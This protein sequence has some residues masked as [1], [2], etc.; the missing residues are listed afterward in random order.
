MRAKI[1]ID[2]GIVNMLHDDGLTLRE[3][4]EQIGV[5]YGT[6]ARRYPAHKDD[7]RSF[8][9]DKA[10]ALRKAG[11]SDAKIADELC[12]EPETVTEELKTR[13][14]LYLSGKREQKE[15]T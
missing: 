2:W 12:T 10:C 13:Y 1:K 15:T 14:P 5:A 7:P 3:I 11:W 4:S 9:W 6:L 8:D